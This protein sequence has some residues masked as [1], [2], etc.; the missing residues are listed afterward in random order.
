MLRSIIID[1]EY[2]VQSYRLIIL[3]EVLNGAFSINGRNTTFLYIVP[4]HE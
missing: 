4:L 1:F 2:C 3:I